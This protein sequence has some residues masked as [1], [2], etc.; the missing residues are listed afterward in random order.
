MQLQQRRN[1]D[2][3]AAVDHTLI[4]YDDFAKDFYTEHPSIAA[5]TD[6]QVDGITA[7]GRVA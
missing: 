5:M 2:P 7:P 4:E 6:Q 3:L 1:I